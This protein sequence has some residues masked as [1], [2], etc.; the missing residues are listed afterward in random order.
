ME[1]LP[2]WIVFA[3]YAAYTLSIAYGWWRALWR[4]RKKATEPNPPATVV[5]P[6]RTEAVRLGPL[7][8]SIQQGLPQLP[9][10]EFLFINDHSEDES[11]LIL[12]NAFADFSQVRILELPAN[13]SGKKAAV[14]FGV[15]AGN[16]PLV[17]TMDAD[18]V[19]NTHAL[20]HMAS[21]LS[22]YP[23]QLVCGPVLQ[24][25]GKNPGARF[26]DLEF[27]SLIGSGISFWGM[28]MPI[29]G[30]AA[31]LGFRK[32][33]FQTVKGFKGNEDYPGGDDVFLLHK[34]HQQ[35]GIEGIHFLT[36]AEDVVQ[37]SGDGSWFEFMQRRIRWGAKARGY[38]GQ[39]AK[40]ITFFTLL[41]QSAAVVCVIGLLISAQFQVLLWALVLKLVCD[42]LLLTP[43]IIRFRQWALLP[44]ILPASPLHPF[45]LFFTA[46]LSLRGQYEWKKRTY[47]P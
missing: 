15:A 17:I 24:D 22:Q 25:S 40:A 47:H 5:V 45:Y 44:Y 7:I 38:Q 13:E 31:F 39:G 29:M 26:A 3:G 28:G 9:G 30:N 16:H 36:A 4:S 12:R 33:A 42:A 8:H 43:V 32:E 37:T 19:V 1:H 14:R 18:C 27:L 41:V 34:I 23:V 2:L 6:F 11:M 10:W 35:Y 46:C 20:R 21:K